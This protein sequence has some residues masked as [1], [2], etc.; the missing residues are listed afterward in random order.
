MTEKLNGGDFLSVF[1]QAKADKELNCFQ[2]G[3]K[4]VIE[5]VR[6]SRTNPGVVLP[7]IWQVDWSNG[8]E[9]D[10]HVYVEWNGMVENVGVT[11]DPQ[12]KY[13]IGP[14]I[15]SVDELH[16]KGRDITLQMIL[17]LMGACEDGERYDS[18]NLL[19]IFNH[20]GDIDLPKRNMATL[21]YLRYTKV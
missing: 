12:T 3:L 5:A 11:C 18:E 10:A 20:L 17:A 6:V 2:N 8:D 13:W 14:D 9:V 19:A 1:P 4:A 16:E 21:T 7:R 15:D